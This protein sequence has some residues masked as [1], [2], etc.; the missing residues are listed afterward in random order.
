MTTDKT[1]ARERA[2]FAAEMAESFDDLREL[3][4]RR[5][6]AQADATRS[7]S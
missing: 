7:A 6:D 2:R 1:T 4:D 3:F 5:G